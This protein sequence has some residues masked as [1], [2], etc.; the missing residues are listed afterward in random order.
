MLQNRREKIIC[1][2]DN[3]PDIAVNTMKNSLELKKF[4][5]IKKNMKEYSKSNNFLIN[6]NQFKINFKS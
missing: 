1:A 2:Q 5:Q 3:L 6:Y 4:R